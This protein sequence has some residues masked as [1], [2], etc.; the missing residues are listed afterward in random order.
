MEIHVVVIEKNKK[1]IINLK[2]KTRSCFE[3]FMTSI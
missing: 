2:R 1:N 3:N